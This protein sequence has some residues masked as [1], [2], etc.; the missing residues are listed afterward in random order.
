M[1][2]SIL[3][4]LSLPPSG[5][6]PSDQPTGANKSSVDQSNGTQTRD[7]T[8]FIK[9]VI[10]LISNEDVPVMISANKR[11]LRGA[12]PASSK[13]A[14]NESM[15]PKDNVKFT[16]VKQ[17][18][19]PK[20]D[21]V[22]QVEE[23]RNASKR[24]SGIKRKQPD[25]RESESDEEEEA[26]G[27][28]ASGEK[29]IGQSLRNGASKVRQGRDDKRTN[30]RQE[31]GAKAVRHGECNRA[32]LETYMTRMGV[33]TLHLPE[34][35]SLCSVFVS[36]LISQPRVVIEKLSVT[37]ASAKRPCT[38]GKSFYIKQENPRRKSPVKAPTH[39]RT[40]NQPQKPD[41]DF[42]GLDDKE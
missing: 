8:P 38:A 35:P 10:G 1:G 4:S 39:K 37:S 22:K 31:D 28:T 40:S 30:E 23:E 13:D 32:V 11:T 6:V 34:D 36:C 25:E 14:T 26:L 33:K 41:S 7:K 24:R 15:D 42:P 20:D 19:T 21:G 29:G 16:A 12:E 2:D 17:R 5:R 3:A 18:Q 27:M 9:P